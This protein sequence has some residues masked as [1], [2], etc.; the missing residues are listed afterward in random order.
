MGEVLSQSEIDNLL[1]ALSSGELDVEDMQSEDEKQVKNYDFSRPTKF[2]KEHLRT[3]EII[4]EHYGRLISTNL[5]AYLRKNVQVTVASSETVTFSEFSNALS[6]PVIL[7]IINFNPLNGMI[8]VDLATNLAYAMLDRMLGGAGTT[9]EKK[10]DFSEIELSIIQKILVMLTQLLREPWRNVIEISPVLSRVETNSQ[11]A[12][13]IAPNDMIAIVTLNVKIGDVEG[14]INFC[15]PFFTLEDVMDRL[16]TKYWFASMQENHDE[17]Y[18][19]HIES[20]VRKVTV[21]IKAV[22]GK[23]T[24]SVSDFLNLQV[25]DCIRLNAK[26]EDDMDIYVGNIRKFTALP[27]ANNDAYAVRITSVVREEE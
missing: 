7:G 21:P 3:L 14:F 10:R 17:D 19:D 16:S 22:L 24:I 5:P 8:I 27:G 11:F 1:A 15:L 6:N 20:L 13:V 18:M 9:L 26:V 12:Q 25:G 23:S 2:S 4:F